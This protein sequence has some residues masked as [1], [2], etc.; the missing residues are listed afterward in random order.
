MGRLGGGEPGCNVWG[1]NKRKK[2][3]GRIKKK[4]NPK[5]Q[6]AFYFIIGLMF[7]IGFTVTG[8]KDM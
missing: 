8:M 5:C 7:T 6:E 3:E 4:E 1:K 2:K